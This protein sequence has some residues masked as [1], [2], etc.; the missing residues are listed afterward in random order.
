MNDGESIVRE[1]EDR[2]ED[3]TATEQQRLSTQ[4][5]EKNVNEEPD[6][7]VEERAEQRAETTQEQDKEQSII[8]E[9]PIE[10]QDLAAE[11]KLD[12][13]SEN[14]TERAG[15]ENTERHKEGGNTEVMSRAEPEP[16][17]EPAKRTIQNAGKGDVDKATK[18]EVE[19][20]LDEEKTNVEPATK[21][22]QDGE[23][24]LPAPPTPSKPNQSLP[25]SSDSEIESVARAF[26]VS[27]RI[28]GRAAEASVERPERSADAERPQIPSSPEKSRGIK[29]GKGPPP[30]TQASEEK[31]FDFNRFLDQMRHKSAG[32]VGEYVRSFIKGFTKKPYRVADQT[33]LIFDFLDF[34]AIRMRECEVW[35]TLTPG[36]FENAMEAM[37][38]LIMNRLYNYTFSP[39]IKREGKWSVQTD[40]LERDRVLKQRIRLF[41]WIDE[42]HLEIPV[43]DHSKGFVDFAIQ[44]LLKL[45]HYKAPRDK[46]ICILNCCKVIFGLIRHLSS[47][48]NADTFVPILIFVVLRA[49]PDNL[50][51]NVEYISRFRNPERLS[52][53]SGYY[54]SSLMGAIAFVETMDYTSLSN[55][56]QQ[57]FEANVESAVLSIS[58]SGGDGDMAGVAERDSE[59]KV[60]IGG[61][62]STS[63]EGKN[64]APNSA[65]MTP[66]GSISSNEDGSARALPISAGA[67]A[68]AKDTRAFIQRTGEAARV[69]FGASLGGGMSALGR[70]FQDGLDGPRTP[71]GSS[72]GTSTGL[73]GP[74]A[75]HV[76]P[77][78]PAGLA[79]RP[80]LPTTGSARARM[81]NLFGVDEDQV[82]G[83]QALKSTRDGQG[84]GQRTASGTSLNL[85]SWGRNLRVDAESDPT[86]PQSEELKQG[87]FATLTTT[88][89]GAP[90]RPLP[91]SERLARSFE[92]RTPRTPQPPLRREST[93]PYM[94][95]N[96]EGVRTPTDD[97]SDFDD[98]TLGNSGRTGQDRTLTQPLQS[99]P[100]PSGIARA[101][102]SDLSNYLPS[103]L[104]DGGPLRTPPNQTYP[105]PQSDAATLL[106]SP[107]EANMDDDQA[108]QAAAQIDRAHVD[109]GVETLRSIFPD[110]DASVCRLV[111][112]NCGGD[113]QAS[114]DK[115]LEMS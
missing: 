77:D 57:E 29:I 85:G 70:L 96:A 38:K 102:M 92:S 115:L 103:F 23:R 100:A 4:G 88:K 46:V 52:S 11:R 76:T 20:R 110:T 54:L 104:T 53:E 79:Q 1:A 40:D 74:G 49:N 65:Q 14:E 75:G 15:I 5:S 9:D 81:W 41:G 32:P 58:S 18:E 31:P 63:S 89:E 59:M 60:I 7:K 3:E 51:S 24:D 71:L 17:P 66:Q 45:N 33:K 34:I 67:A 8:K 108:V 61:P 43:G 6:E 48:E 97:G 12:T 83:Q 111:L 112:E 84:G 78:S 35:A 90:S 106:A 69:G 25:N 19:V 109:A 13:G 80:E 56:T 95:D 93:D 55:I 62:A 82:K 94:V 30:S 105:L 42:S 37:E 21:Y 99:R 47:Q 16:A 113:V 87:R 44:E 50:I 98:S 114:I 86:T 36:D 72:P 26:G 101:R 2:K 107:M 27:T 64:T 39:A 28:D 68:L 73:A 22:E 91:L 10:A